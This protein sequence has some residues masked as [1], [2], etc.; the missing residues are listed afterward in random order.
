MHWFALGLGLP[1]LVLVGVLTLKNAAGS[2]PAA[3]DATTL[4]VPPAVEAALTDLYADTEP[5]GSLIVPAAQEAQAFHP[6][7]AFADAQYELLKYTIKS[8]DT[9]ERLFRR[10]K[11][12]LGDLAEIVRLKDAAEYLRMLRPGNEFDIRHS[13]GR[14]M[15]LYRKLN[16]T[17]S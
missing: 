2:K 17:Q 9:L 12:S 1:L 5:F 10:N 14:L 4:I 11:I 3:S 13:D 8:G 7:L 16:L 15:S 6:P